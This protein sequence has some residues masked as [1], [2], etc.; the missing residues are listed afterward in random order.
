MVLYVNHEYYIPKQTVGIARKMLGMVPMA[1]E[2]MCYD[3][4]W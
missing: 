2:G 1:K 3:G 4:N